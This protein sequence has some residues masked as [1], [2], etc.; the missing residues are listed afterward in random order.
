MEPAFWTE[1]WQ[2]ND[3]GFHQKSAH[4]LLVRYWPQMNVPEGS[5]VLVPL[6]GK[7][8]DMVW[9]AEQGHEVFGIELSQVAIDA[10][11]VERGLVPATVPVDGGV[12]K[13]GGPYSLLCGDFFKT[14]PAQTAHVSAVYDR[15]A[16]VALPPAM[17]KDYAQ[18]LMSLIKPGTKTLLIGLDYDS[19]QMEGPPFAVARDEIEA[20]YRPYGTVEVLEERDVIGTHPHFKARGATSLIETAYRLERR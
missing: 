12:L 4:D 1:R 13:M 17:R 8:L 3:I 2:K 9:L 7:S 19:L 15:A 6:S 11:F 10:F 5:A 16:L 14:R 18:H 20:L